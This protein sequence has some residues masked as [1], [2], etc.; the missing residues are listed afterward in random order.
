[1]RR[2]A[3]W[4]MSTLTMLVLLFSYHTSLSSTVAVTAPPASLALVAPPVGAAVAAGAD[5]PTGRGPAPGTPAPKPTAAAP[6]TFNG[7]A[8]RT[9]YGNVQVQITV[10]NGKITAARA[11]QA[12]M[13]DR[14]DQE[15]NS[16]AV[17][18]YN[19]EVVAV[20]SAKIDA[21]SGATVTWGG[22]TQSLQS[23]LDQA[24]L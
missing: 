14:H 9:E 6:R 10:A 20:Q 24:H 4:T 2:I 5:P 17:P 15:I 11:L 3:L 1:M 18:I 23:A 19:G 7:Q 16:R 12:P 21:V 13:E 8:V 22:Y